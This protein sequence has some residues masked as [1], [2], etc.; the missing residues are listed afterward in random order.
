MSLERTLMSWVR[1]GTALIAFGFTIYRFLDEVNHTPGAVQAAQPYA[2][3][4]VGLTLIGGGIVSLVIAALEYRELTN[5]LWHERYK[6]VAGV[7]ET[8]G[9][10]PLLA[11]TMLLVLA[12]IFAFLA[13][14][15]RLP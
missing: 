2:A 3:Q 15:L 5:Y 12:G 7:R 10:S 13:V 8:P 1:T 4:I 6:P 11:L 14:A 9:A